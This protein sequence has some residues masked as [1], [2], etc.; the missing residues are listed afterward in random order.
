MGLLFE[1]VICVA[2]FGVANG[3]GAGISYANYGLDWTG[4]CA[5]GTSQSPINLDQM[6]S[7]VDTDLGKFTFNNYNQPNKYGN[8]VNTGTT[9]QVGMADL[10]VTM[11]GGGLDGTGFTLAQ[12]H[13]HWGLD[14]TSGSE[15]TI[16]NKMYPMEIHFVHYKTSL[17]DLTAAAGIPNGL[18]VLGFMF[19]LSGSDNSDLDFF[20]DRVKNVSLKDS[21]GVA[22]ET[23]PA[24]QN[25]F[26][27]VDTEK[28]FRY[29]GS[30]TTPTC[31]EVVQWT[32]FKDPIKI[33]EAQMTKIRK[34][35][36][37]TTGTKIIGFNYRPI[38]SQGT[39]IVKMS[40][41]PDVSA[42]S[43][44]SA[45]SLLVAVFLAFYYHA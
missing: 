4:V 16:D 11:S 26:R 6:L 40:F 44:L 21:F 29:S 18:A 37:D 31:N 33:S 8:I 9:I 35:Y 7:R 23:E 43:R 10:S 2:L 42:S 14:S 3:A 41:Q 17:G 20:I 13:L 38:Q 27:G 28:F 39:R 36:Q 1:F 5:T 25:I 34:S 22:L 12:F 30:L 15:H 24:V 32:V 19:E 45:S